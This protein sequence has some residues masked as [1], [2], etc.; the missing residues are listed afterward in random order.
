LSGGVEIAVPLE[1]LIDFAREKERI[2]RET[3]KLVKELEKIE[4]QLSN[5]QFVERAPAEKVEDL[6]QRA[7][8]IK[9]RIV[10]L[11]QMKEALG[12]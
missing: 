4:A 8:D 6:R 2:G 1:G 3:E 9:Q 7:A 12:G 11:E 5:Q 10:A